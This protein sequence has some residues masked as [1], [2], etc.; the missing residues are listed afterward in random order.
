MVGI[1]GGYRGGRLL[2]LLEPMYK[3]LHFAAYIELSV[4][5]HFGHQYIHDLY[6]LVPFGHT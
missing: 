2:E 3:P 1:G 4:L 6:V 5:V